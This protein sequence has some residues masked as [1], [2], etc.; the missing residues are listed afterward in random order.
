MKRNLRYTAGILFLVFGLC[1]ANFNLA[2][3]A[4]VRG[5]GTPLVSG[6]SP[7]IL[8]STIQAPGGVLLDGFGG[9]HPFGGY[10]LNGSGAPYWAGWDIARSLQLVPGGG[11]GWEL[12]GF[13]GI[14]PFGGAPSLGTSPYWAGWDIARSLVVYMGPNGQFQGY[15][16]DGFGGIHPL[17][18][19]PALSGAPYWSGFDVARG[20]VLSFDSNGV[21]NGGMTLDAWGGLHPFGSF[22]TAGLNLNYYSGHDV[23]LHLEEVSG[24]PYAVGVYGVVTPLVSSSDFSANWSGYPDWGKLE[25]CKRCCHLFSYRD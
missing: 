6:G 12:D 13:G 7:P 15:E 4:S 9:L 16:L 18:G 20:L 1:F 5:E 8:N 24:I 21:P 11:G 3:G 2:M 14:H 22:S 17:N 19:A 25:Y 23:Y 10:P